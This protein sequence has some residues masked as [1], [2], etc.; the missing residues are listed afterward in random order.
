MSYGLCAKFC[1]ICQACCGS[2]LSSVV[3]ITYR[4]GEKG[5]EKAH[6]CDKAFHEKAG[7]SQMFLRFRVHKLL[8]CAELPCRHPSNPQSLMS[9]V[10][11]ASW[12]FS[13][14]PVLPPV[15]RLLLVS[16]D[17]VGPGVIRSHRN[18]ALGFWGEGPV[19]LLQADF[20]PATPLESEIL[21]R[22]GL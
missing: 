13:F 18:S 11:A 5:E 15:K 12:A 22:R 20:T 3:R 10:L 2:R 21:S 4:S 17:E 1:R 19:K 14:Q 16:E 6:T 9:I 8:F 7:R